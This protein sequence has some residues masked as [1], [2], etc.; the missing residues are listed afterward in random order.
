MQAISHM[1]A[2]DLLEEHL[3]PA[4]AAAS[5]AASPETCGAVESSPKMSEDHADPLLQLVADAALLSAPDQAPTTKGTEDSKGASFADLLEETSARGK[6]SRTSDD[7]RALVL[8]AAAPTAAETISAPLK[9]SAPA[10][11]LLLGGAVT[12][13]KPALKDGAIALPAGMILTAPKELAVP[14]TTTAPTWVSRVVNE[15]LQLH[16]GGGTARLQVEV[17]QVGVCECK[18]T[19]R[20]DSVQVH[21]TVPPSPTQPLQPQL[22]ALS[23]GLRSLGLQVSEVVVSIGETAAADEE[24]PPRD[25]SQNQSQNQENES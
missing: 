7:P 11:A 20:G 16:Q 5:R 14:S 19:V 15:A 8:S 21:L 2:L 3:A 24:A 25:Q 1:I 6:K 10:L 12:S 9:L 13:E 22:S 18:V 23:A 17:P 4:S